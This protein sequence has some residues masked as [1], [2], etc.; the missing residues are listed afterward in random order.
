MHYSFGSLGSNGHGTEFT[1]YRT[2]GAKAI[3]TRAIATITG[4]TEAEY[5]AST[6]EE[7]HAKM[8]ESGF[9]IPTLEQDALQKLQALNLD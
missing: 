6:L 4:N 7:R 1:G 3:F 8:Q 5:S 2:E 9:E